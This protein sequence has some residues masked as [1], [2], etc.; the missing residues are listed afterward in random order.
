MTEETK[1][2]PEDVTELI[3]IARQHGLSE[4]SVQQGETRVEIRLAAVISSSA[5][6]ATTADSATASVTVPSSEVRSPMTGVF[7]DSPS[8][9]EPSFVHPGDIVHEGET[10]GLIEAMKVFSEVPSDRTGRMRRAVAENGQLVQEGDVLIEL[11]PLDRT[12]G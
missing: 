4:L 3:R 1:L 8:P 9:G 5:S 7:Y 2:P 6:A 10:I 11:S 12:E